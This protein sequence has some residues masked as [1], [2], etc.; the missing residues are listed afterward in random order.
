MND[1]AS[2]GVRTRGNA[3]TAALQFSGHDMLARRKPIRTRRRPPPQP[4]EPGGTERLRLPPTSLH[5]DNDIEALVTAL[6]DVWTRLTSRC[7]A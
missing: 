2:T 3:A 4:A 1:P 7:A 5:S 6:S